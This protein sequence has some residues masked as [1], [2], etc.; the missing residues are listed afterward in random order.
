MGWLSLRPIYAVYGRTV[1]DAEDRG[2]ERRSSETP[3]EYSG[4][5]SRVLDAP[6]FAEVAA[7]FDAARYGDHDPD[8]GEVQRWAAELDTWERTHP[9]SDELR[10]RLEQMRPP[11]APRQVDPGE[12]FAARVKQGKE[13]AK[14][15]RKGEGL[16][17]EAPTP[18]RL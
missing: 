15:L 7:A 8:P 3:L 16:E 6:F 11:R 10:A 1:I 4:A 12:E 17:R 14:Q 5:S 2:F 13:I 18:N 9:P